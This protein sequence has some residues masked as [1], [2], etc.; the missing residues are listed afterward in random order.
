MAKEE[1]RIILFGSLFFVISLLPFL[2][3]GN[4]TSRYSY[5]SS[6]GFILLFVFFLKKVYG[7]LIFNGRQITTAI[8]V[9]IISVFSLIHMIQLQKINR[10]WGE[11]GEKSKRFLISLNRVYENSWRKEPMTFYFINV[12]IRSGEAW[13]FPVGIND[14]IWF[15]LRNERVKVYQLPSLKQALDQV[16]PSANEK[17]FEFDDSGNFV[18]RNKSQ[19]ASIVQQK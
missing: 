17:V 7:Y 5:M 12:P 9:V 1:Q 15:V 2:G 4:I 16:K 19:S 14:A 13:I 10:D 3:L 6:I 18:E 11:A 8:L